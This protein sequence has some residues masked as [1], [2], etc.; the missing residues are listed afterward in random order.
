M[1]HK[2]L[3]IVLIIDIILPILSLSYSDSLVY[4][5]NR[6]GSWLLTTETIYERMTWMWPESL[7]FI[8]HKG[9]VIMGA[10]MGGIGTALSLFYQQFDEN[11][12]RFASA[13][14]IFIYTFG[15]FGVLGV[16]ALFVLCKKHLKSIGKMI[17]LFTYI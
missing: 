17:S 10:G 5:G 14:N 3:I 13:D 12:L 2:I 6:G 9:N 15:L 16:I 8:L 11:A 4:S 1:L 7:S